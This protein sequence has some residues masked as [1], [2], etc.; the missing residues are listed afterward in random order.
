MKIPSILSDKILNSIPR[1]RE[2][3]SIWQGDHLTLT[4]VDGT[5]DFDATKMSLDDHLVRFVTLPKLFDLLGKKRLVLSR[6]DQHIKGDPFECQARRSY[7]NISTK[8]LKKRALALRKYIMKIAP[9]SGGDHGCSESWLK[10]LN[11]KDTSANDLK[12]ITWRL[13]QEALKR[14]LAFVCWCKGSDSSDAM[15]RVYGKHGAAIF[16][17]VSR[18]KSSLLKVAVPKVCARDVKLALASVEYSNDSEYD[19]PW[20]LKREAFGHEKEV[21][22]Y[23][24]L[25]LTKTAG[26]EIRVSVP[27]LIQKIELSPFAEF[28]EC[29]AIRSA[30]TALLEKAGAPHVQ[31]CQ[32]DH[33]RPPSNLLPSDEKMV[34]EVMKKVFPPVSY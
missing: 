5:L 26:T 12:A 15:W 17:S 8:E 29:T 32:S 19:E 9:L 14:Q 7:A 23:C 3:R 30:T 2:R 11:L 20:L 28:W 1:D 34:R 33:M 13:E 21:R 31:V 4:E 10:N 18:L 24:D 25:P 22:L 16:T 6:L 27:T